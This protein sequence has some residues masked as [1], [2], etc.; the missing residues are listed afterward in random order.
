MRSLILALLIVLLV[1]WGCGAERELLFR[2]RDPK[3]DDRGAGELLYPEHAVYQRG[4]FDLL[5][6]EVSADAEHL[7]FDFKFAEVTNPF[8]APEGY[9]HQ[10]LEVFIR[11]EEQASR[12]EIKFGRHRLQT[13][14]GLGWDLRL[15]IAPF[16]ESRIYAGL[17]EIA[18]DQVVSLV[19]PDQ[20]TIRL[21][22]PKDLL[23]H[24][25][26]AW[27]YYVLVGA[28]DGLAQD[29]IRDLGSGPWDV[30]G[31]GVPIFDLL[32]PRFS[33]PSQRAQ[34]S[35]GIL[36]PV[37]RRVIPIYYLIA[38]AIILLISLFLWRWVR[39]T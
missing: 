3:G 10:R 13:N 36:K 38:G 4:L 1:T 20:K 12:E 5:N 18:S 39:G 26:H 16:G 8:G 31:E 11:T 24:P 14:P 37:F 25:N 9:F 30:G 2:S 22:V 33:M 21:K 19:L 15:S 23:P 35:K 34:L 17:Q 28:F 6:F 29:F 7:Y 27:G 32:A